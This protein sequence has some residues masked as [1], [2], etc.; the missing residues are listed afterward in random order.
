MKETIIVEKRKI[1]KLKNGVLIT[2]LPGI[3]L[4]GQISARYLVQELGAERV[5]TVLS[6]HFSHHVFMTKKGMMR[7]VRNSLFLYRGK[8]TD[9]LIL[10]GDIQPVTSVGQYE[11]AG[12]ILDYVQGLGV[13][14]IIS[15]GGYSSGKINKTKRIFGVVNKKDLKKKFERLGVKFGKAK[16]AIV[17]AA[18]LLPALGRLRKIR[19]SCLMGETHGS[20]IDTPAA[21]RMVELLS[22]YL[23][24]KVDLRRIEKQA[25]ESEKLIKKIEEEIKKTVSETPEPTKGVSYIR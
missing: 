8:K 18:G 4:I 14:E 9:L 11:V 7:I 10:V 17:G 5:A 2:G 6:P 19:G 15:I 12:K 24:I 1:K 20:Y 13:K 16:G 3:G 23:G 22:A 21:S 25:K